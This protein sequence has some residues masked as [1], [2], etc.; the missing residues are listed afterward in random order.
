VTVALQKLDAK[1]CELIQEMYDS[2]TT[3][4]STTETPVTTTTSTTEIA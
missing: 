3:T 2:T 1:L 4:T